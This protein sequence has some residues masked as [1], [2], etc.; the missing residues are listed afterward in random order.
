MI[1][2][3]SEHLFDVRK[4]CSQRNDLVASIS[5]G[6]VGVIRQ[7]ARKPAVYAQAHVSHLL[8]IHR[9]MFAMP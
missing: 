4:F 1:C 7:I 8:I 9:P 2:A 6:L 5:Q 3:F